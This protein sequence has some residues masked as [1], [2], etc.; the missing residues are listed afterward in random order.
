MTIRMASLDILHGVTVRLCYQ[1]GRT[2]RGKKPGRVLP[3]PLARRDGSRHW[4][5]MVKCALESQRDNLSH[6]SSRIA[7]LTLA[8]SSGVTSRIPCCFACSAAFFS[9]SSSVVPLMTCVHPDD[10]STLAHSTIFPMIAP[11]CSARTCSYPTAVNTLNECTNEK[12][13]LRT[14][15][16]RVNGRLLSSLRWMQIW[17]TGHA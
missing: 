12:E 5:S 10:G 7:A 13:I 2:E 11:P 15:E 9:T 4:L 14:L 3:R 17:G 8:L 6:F 1:V 16:E